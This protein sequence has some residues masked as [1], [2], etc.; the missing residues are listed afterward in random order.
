VF[1]HVGGADIGW[2]VEWRIAVC[3]ILA[4]NEDLGVCPSCNTRRMAETA[5]HWVDH[6]F[7]PL[8]VRQWVLS[9]PKRLRSFL[10]QDR[11]TVTAV[12]NIFLPVVEQ[13]LRDHAP[14]STE[15]AR[16]GAVS[17]VRRFGSAL[18]EH[19]HFPCCVIAG[20]LEPG[21]Q[22]GEAVRFREAA[23]TAEAI[24]GVQARVRQRALR[25]FATR[26]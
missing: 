16:L 19:L 14:G 23:L 24:Q 26:G 9:L 18:N 8:P 17:F 4:R 20:V 10:R 13:A 21:P 12:L 25:W 2:T 1:G 22:G 15:K 11:R 3:G 5:A 6:V 7:P